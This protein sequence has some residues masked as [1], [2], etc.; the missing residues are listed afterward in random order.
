MNIADFPCPKCKAVLEL[1]DVIGGQLVDCPS[2]GVP[3]KIPF[4]L[5]NKEEKFCSECGEKIRIKAVVCPKCGCAQNSHDSSTTFNLCIPRKN[6][7][8]AGF[9]ALILGG[10]GIHYFY[11]GKNVAGVIC[12]LFCWTW[13]PL[14]AGLIEGITFLTMTDEKFKE[15]YP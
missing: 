5:K 9:L 15:K 11:L 8:T 7:T 10:I 13:I 4:D 12:V 3:F 2:C 6:R 1:E 14:V